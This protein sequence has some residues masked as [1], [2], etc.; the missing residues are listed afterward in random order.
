M[1]HLNYLSAQL[2]MNQQDLCLL[3]KSLAE[4]VV[5]QDFIRQ[6]LEVNDHIS[7]MSENN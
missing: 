6:V 5:D 3:L 4:A 1:V 7:E 2:R